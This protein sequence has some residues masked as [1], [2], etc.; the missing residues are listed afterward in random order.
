MRS[1]V[2]YKIAFWVGFGLHI[3]YVYSRSRILSMECI[4]PSCTSLY[5]ADVPLSILYLAMPPAIII[6]ASFALGS[7]LLGLYSMGLM[8]LLEKIFK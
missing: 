4:N 2:N 5:L 1:N 7:I 6:V 3:V 8:R